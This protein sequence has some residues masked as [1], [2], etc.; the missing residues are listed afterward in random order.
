MSHIEEVRLMKK[1][2]KAFFKRAIDSLN[3]GDYDVASFLAEQAVQLALKSLILEKLGDYPRTHSL[4]RLA[5]LLS[6]FAEH[7]DL[8]KYL[9]ENW[10]ELRLMEDAY[11]AS[12]Y[13]LREYDRQEAEALIRLA[14][15]VLK[16]GG[17][18]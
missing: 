1:R 9:E 13:L 11:I 12:R 14:R 16:H 2:A 15:G 4:R 3:D 7:K 6:K 5:N 8:V 18:L 17:I 10:R